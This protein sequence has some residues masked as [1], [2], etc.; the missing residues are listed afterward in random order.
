MPSTDPDPVEGL[1]A[2][3]VCWCG[4]TLAYSECHGDLMPAS[5]PGD[6]LPPDPADGVYLSPTVVADLTVLHGMA[7]QA[8]GMPVYAPTPQAVQRPIE[9]G[10][11]MARL[12]AEP[13]R[14]PTVPLAML[15]STRY[16][17]LDGL[18]LSDLERLSSRV[19]A[20]SK[21]ESE[22]LLYGLVDLGKSVLDR[23][24]EQ[25]A[26]ENPTTVLWIDGASAPEIVGRTLFWADHYLVADR[27]GA[28]ALSNP[29]DLGELELAIREAIELRPLVTLGMVVPIL[30]DLASAAAAIA[31][32]TTTA[33]DLNDQA[34]V[35]WVKRQIV[36]E[37]PTAR[38]AI[39]LRVRDEDSRIA[40]RFY[41]YGDFKPGRSDADGMIVTTELLGPYDPEFDYSEWIDQSKRQTA[42]ALIQE[43][44]LNLEIAGAVGG[45]FVTRAPFQARLMERRGGITADPASALVWADV[46]VLRA[47]PSAAL[48][49]AAQEDEAVDALRSTV[50]R[51]FRSVARNGSHEDR[52]AEA[53]DLAE[54]LN[55][56]QEH[57]KETIT[58]ERRWQLLVPTALGIG[59]LA[60]GATVG[61]LGVAA[62]LLSGWAGLAPYRAT[63]LQH[64]GEAAYALLVAE[65]RHR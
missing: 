1:L 44:N 37:G 10:A 11:G 54:E 4:S 40:E 22:E 15:A 60:L 29:V 13:A 5:N 56:A 2:D 21:S 55:G 14:T 26:A 51:S 62:G 31:A 53:R 8:V 17:L 57:L 19:R 47:A 58:R 61:P 30:A 52:R 34:L 7:R 45:H 36:V 59:G 18:G 25:A 39:F 32:E 33:S 3:D 12:V 27:L 46:P 28:A 64:R 43:T 42:A 49:A 50:R 24:L 6:P 35:E 20:L 23:L 38:Q 41:I 65:R 48:A 63:E 9:V 16:E